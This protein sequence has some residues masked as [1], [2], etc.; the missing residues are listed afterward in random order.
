MSRRHN[1]K[2]QYLAQDIVLLRSLCGTELWL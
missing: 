1:F 2:S